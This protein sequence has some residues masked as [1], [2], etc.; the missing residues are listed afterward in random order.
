[1]T[2]WLGVA[3]AETGGGFPWRELLVLVGVVLTVVGGVYTAKT[4]RRTTTDTAENNS[5]TRADAITQKQ[6][7]R[8]QE[9][10]TDL[11]K[12]REDDRIRHREELK[13]RDDRIS[14]IEQRAERLDRRVE[15][16]VAVIRDAS[17]VVP[18]P[19]SD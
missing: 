4:S 6:F 14:Q 3:V 8:M 15:Q 10:I 2:A 16:L 9:E 17:L 19:L 5:Y 18:P 13:D 1:L 7:E 11:R 12:D